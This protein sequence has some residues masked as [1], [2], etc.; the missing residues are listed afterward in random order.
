MTL[1]QLV[2]RLTKLA[3]NA[4]SPHIRRIAPFIALVGDGVETMGVHWE[5]QYMRQVLLIVGTRRI[6]AKYVH[7]KRSPRRRGGIVF[8]QKI[9]NRLGPIVRGIYTLDDAI[10]FRQRPSL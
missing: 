3:A 1:K 2:Q 10:A 8:Q 6:V 7:P 4:K 5:L 9:G